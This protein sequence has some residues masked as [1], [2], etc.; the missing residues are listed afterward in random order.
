[1]KFKNSSK[2]IFTILAIVGALAAFACSG[3]KT[4][5]G[6]AQNQTKAP[7]VANPANTTVSTGPVD[8]KP[9]TMT[10]VPVGNAQSPSEAYRM[11]FAA[12]KSQD[13]AKIKSML[14]KNTMGLAQRASGMQKKSIE[15]VIKNGFTQTTFSDTM[16]Q[17]RDERVKGNFGAVEVWNATLKQWDDVQFLLEDGSWKL[18]IGDAFA[19]KWESPGKSQG[20]IERENAN[21]SNPNTMIQKLPAANTNVSNLPRKNGRISKPSNQ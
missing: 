16:P 7:N 20:V 15:E 9:P 14:S 8:D 10:D 3:S 12:V 6:G 2:I 4:E 18:A 17:L 21:A 5:N 1:M 13:S 19:G 11:L